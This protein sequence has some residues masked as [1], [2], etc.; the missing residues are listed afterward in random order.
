[1]EV[2]FVG[3]FKKLSG[4]ARNIEA[5]PSALSTVSAQLAEET[6][7]LIRE[8]FELERD[9]YG[10]RWAKHSKLTKKI[11]PNGRIL[12]GP[13]GNLR[14]A[15]HVKASSRQ[16]FE[17]ANAKRYAIFHQ[18]GTGIHGPK[19]KPIKPKRAKALRI[20]FGNGAFFL[21][22]VAGV[23]PRKMVPDNGRIPRRWSRRYAE[24]AQE[25]LTDIFRRF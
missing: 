5:V 15:W 16:D 3:G 24:V 9:P 10:K 25:V 17:V 4:F 8:G 6:I 18:D 21:S 11:R 1:M 20:P 13:T 22:Q 14:T 12:Q 7:E 19:N 23:K 2:V